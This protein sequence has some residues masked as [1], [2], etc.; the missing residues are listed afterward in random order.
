MIVTD[1]TGPDHNPLTEL[2][3]VVAARRELEQREATLVRRARNA[4]FAWEHIATALDV[5]R[6]AV[7]KKY[8][9]G[10]RRRA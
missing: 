7:H 2:R 1:T 4:G 8:A 5:T 10:L 9:A 3:E 6:Q